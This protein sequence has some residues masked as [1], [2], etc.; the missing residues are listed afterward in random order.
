[1]KKRRHY[2]ELEDIEL[3]VEEDRRIQGMI[4]AAEE[5]LEATR[6]SFRWNRDSIKVVKTAAKLIGVPYQTFMKQVIYEH[7][8][9]VLKDARS[10]KK[11]VDGA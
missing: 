2:E 4:D 3:S 6:V 5:E 1:M 7:S 11:S 9:Q 10:I 8:L